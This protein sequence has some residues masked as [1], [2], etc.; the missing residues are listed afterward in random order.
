MT[1]FLGPEIFMRFE[2][3]QKVFLMTLRDR[4]RDQEVLGSFE[5]RM[6]GYNY[7]WQKVVNKTKL[8]N[9]FFIVFDY[10]IVKDFLKTV[11]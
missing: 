2:K 4:F 10:V 9:A 6:P 7:T 8:K 1:Y 11:N 3:H 5:K